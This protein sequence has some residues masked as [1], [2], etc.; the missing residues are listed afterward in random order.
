MCFKT[1]KAQSRV[2]Q[3]VSAETV[4]VLFVEEEVSASY[5]GHIVA[6][7]A[8]IQSAVVGSH[9]ISQLRLIILVDI[10]LE[11]S[12]EV[13]LLIAKLSEISLKREIKS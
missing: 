2:A 4:L 12:N 5:K 11:N 6:I 3:S 9:L 7:K 8:Q 10:A 13:A 1:T